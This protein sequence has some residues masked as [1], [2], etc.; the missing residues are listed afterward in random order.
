MKHVNAR[1]RRVAIGLA[2]SA[3]SAVRA[4]TPANDLCSNALPA[5]VPSVTPGSTTA[6][7]H[8]G[9][10]QCGTSNTAPG[11]WYSVIGTGGVIVA[12]T[13]DAPGS[14]GSASYDTKISVF[15][16]TCAGLVCVGGNDDNCFGGT[17]GL[18][19]TVS[20]CSEPGQQYLVLVHGFGGATGTFTLAINDGGP[21]PEGACCFNDGSCI[22][23]TQPD[24]QSNGG[25]YQGALTDCGAV[26]CAQ[27]ITSADGAWRAVL[28]AAG[29]VAGL[30]PDDQPVLDNVFETLVYEAGSH[31]GGLSRRVETNYTVTAGPIVDQGRTH[32]FT[33]LEKA[34]GAA[35][36]IEIENFMISNPA[37]GVL[38][39]IR[40]INK[41]AEPVGTKLFYYCD[42]DISQTA[43]NDE[44]QT[45]IDPGTSRLLAIEQ[46][47]FTPPGKPLWFGGCPNYKSWQ[48]D[49]FPALRNALDAGVG[50][51][52]SIDTTLAGPAD[53]A[54]A[55]STEEAFLEPGESIE[56]QVGIGAP[57]FSACTEDE[58]PWDCGDPANGVVDVIDILAL[59]AQY[60]A[61]APVGCDGGSCD[62]DGNGCVDV[63]DLLTLLG[64]WDQVCAITVPAGIDCWH[65]ACG[66]T[67]ASFCDNPIPADFFS[68]GSLPFDGLVFLSGA[69]PGPDTQV[70]RLAD[71]VFPSI[72]VDPVEVTVPIEIV[73]LSLVSCQ[74]IT[75]T[76]FQ[77]P[78]FWNVEVDPS[79][80]PAP[81]GTMTVRKT[82]RNGGVFTST[83]FVQPV[84]TF[85]NV[86]NPN[87]V[88]VLDTGLEGLPP[89][90]LI[91]AGEAPWVHELEPNMPLEGCTEDFHPGI[92]DPDIHGLGPTAQCCVP[93]CHSGA[94][95]DHCVVA[96]EDC[97]M[98]PRGAC[99]LGGGACVLALD[100]GDCAGLGGQYKGDGTTCADSDGD[101]LPDV[102]ESNDCCSPPGPCNR[103]SSP[104]NPDTDGDGLPDG[105]DPDPCVFN[106]P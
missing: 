29:Q 42:F 15:T 10:G 56:M 97:T 22:S 98:C 33:R 38:V 41:G 102:L 43:G 91:I 52:L 66:A 100:A 24:C 28:D 101:Q 45:I 62:F 16:G 79:Q 34:D 18:R 19:S 50:Q 21:C 104:V 105:L 67:K 31:S 48:I 106:P 32:S 83:L 96:S 53:H 76:T 63:V 68:P 93:V 7:T 90:I 47:D 81:L 92:F 36:S 12:T 26:T 85:T 69:A 103:G 86:Q 51:L 64:M 80:F 84:F 23:A 44:A 82:H 95:A 35:L 40:A 27:S 71:M 58:C 59:L 88:R 14:G 89:D 65:T 37:G 49:L 3:V 87:D 11:V 20:W 94:T 70:R 57:G 77:G 8:D 72:I 39:K 6:A 25:A 17:S 73:S 46:V 61:G 99:C 74:P 4:G 60:D 9:V 5:A 55:L 1:I 30:F 13:C 54:S 2:A 75:V 78:T